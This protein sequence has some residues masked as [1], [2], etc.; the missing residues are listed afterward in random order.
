MTRALNF[1]Q[2]QAFKAVMETGTTTRAAQ[3]LNTTQPS[4][5]RRLAELHQVSGLTLFD[6]HHGRLRPTREAHQ[7]Y[8]SV[9]R[10][11]DGLEQIESAVRV[12][13]KSGTGVLRI[14]STPTLATGLLPPVM[15]EFMQKNPGV[16]VNLQTSAT[17]QLKEWLS[18]GML[19]FVLTT[20]HF[21]HVDVNAETL[22]HTRAVCVLPPGHSLAACGVLD[23]RQLR[24]QRL[25]LLDENDDI[26]NA[27]RAS[28][29]RLN[30]HDDLVVETNSSITICA[31]VAAGIG[32]GIVNPFVASTFA[33]RLVVRAIEPM[34]PV[35][36]TLARSVALAPSVLAS[37]FT[38]LLGTW[39]WPDPARHSM[40]PA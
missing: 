23:L 5:S 22:L 12:L 31:L 11:F 20:G 1:Q 33:D 37:R 18:Q 14:G 10:H 16:Y 17:A 8:R 4:I 15:A 19:D 29:R 38:T 36:V 24:G 21:E 30:V 3:V 7:L 6:L 35:E 25:I 27:M 39:S 40:P 2:I 26:R 13:R 28:L 9:R 34:V 32:A